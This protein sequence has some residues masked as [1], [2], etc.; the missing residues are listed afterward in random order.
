[1]GAM[2]KRLSNMLFSKEFILF[3]GPIDFGPNDS[4]EA[5]EL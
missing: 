1:M 4:G 2:A 3:V 5:P